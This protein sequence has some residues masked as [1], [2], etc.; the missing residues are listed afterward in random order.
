MSMRCPV[1]ARVVPEATGYC[2]RCGASLNVPLRL[3]WV[4]E[5]FWACPECQRDEPLVAQQPLFGGARL[6][7]RA[8]GAAWRFDP[9]ARTLA[10]LDPRTR[11]HGPARP[12]EEWLALLPP[13]FSG[14]THPAPGLLLLPTEGCYL[15]VDR[16]R[17]LAPRQSVQHAQPMG[18]V[19]LLPGIYERVGRDPLGPRPG[20]LSTLARGPFIVTDRRIVFLGNR[21]HVESALNRLEGVEVDEGYL[22]LHRTSRTDTFRFEDESAIR[23]R[24]A[25][26]ALQAAIVEAERAQELPDV[27]EARAAQVTRSAGAE[28]GP[29]LTPPAPSEV[30][31][32]GAG[33]PRP[34][35]TG[36]PDS[37]PTAT[38]RPGA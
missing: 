35:A 21:K 33:M 20:Q 4:A 9:Q 22:L 23:V 7:C 37:M 8:C 29:A 34:G 17:M 26:L 19:S 31:A 24:A 12:L 14:L 32:A 3:R 16:A 36:I 30:D 28:D 15:R 18:R 13:P 2:P 5:L 11:E 38:E 6:G 10:Q 25:I 27:P 1:C